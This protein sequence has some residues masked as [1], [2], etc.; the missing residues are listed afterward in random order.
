MAAWEGSV[1]RAQIETENGLE[2][3]E[4]TLGFIV[5]LREVIKGYMGKMQG[6]WGLYFVEISLAK[7][8]MMELKEL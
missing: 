2:G 4:S 1:V 6:T 3:R 5:K 8:W 7:L